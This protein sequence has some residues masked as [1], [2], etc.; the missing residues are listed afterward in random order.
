MG[1]NLSSANSGGELAYSYRSKNAGMSYHT[2]DGYNR[3]LFILPRNKKRPAK[4][5]RFLFLD[6]G[7]G[8]ATA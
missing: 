3:P 6:L 4:T 1:N 8:S 7:P 2:G 5:G